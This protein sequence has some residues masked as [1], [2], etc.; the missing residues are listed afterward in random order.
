MT[1]PSRLRAAH[2]CAARLDQK[3]IRLEEVKPANYFRLSFARCLVFLLREAVASISSTFDG[4][5]SGWPTDHSETTC[6]LRPFSLFVIVR[7]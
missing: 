1:G 5:L 7:V 2:Y 3:K 6:F 4:K